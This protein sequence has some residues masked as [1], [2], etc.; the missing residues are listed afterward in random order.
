MK[1]P[2]AEIA[3]V[4]AAAA[5]AIPIAFWQGQPPG[6]PQ[7]KPTTPEPSYTVTVKLSDINAITTA[8]RELMQ[9]PDLK[10]P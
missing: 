8:L 10:T 9:K 2:Y 6:L 5:I 1:I 3:M 7:Y 4:I